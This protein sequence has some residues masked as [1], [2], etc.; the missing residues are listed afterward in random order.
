MIRNKL[1]NFL[2]LIKYQKDP[3]KS[4]RST[5]IQLSP[6]IQGIFSSLSGILML[7]GAA[8]ALLMIMASAV[9]LAWN[10]KGNVRAE[11]KASV[12]YRLELVVCLFSITFI[13]GLFK[14]IADS[15]F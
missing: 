2:L 14:A 13:L 5:K 1:E 7:I 12:L 4:L 10:R 11:V 15:L 9:Y 3:W 8:G 6:E